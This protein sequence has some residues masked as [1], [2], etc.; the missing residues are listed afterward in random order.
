LIPVKSFHD[1]KERLAGVLSRAERQQLA[2]S[3]AEGVISALAS[4]VVC[5]V[6]DDDEVASWARHVGAGVVWAPG[7]GL[8]PAVATG[9]D[10]LKAQ[11]F[12][13]VTIVHA[14]LP[15]P[16]RLTALPSTEGALLVPDR[17]GDGTNVLR[18]PTGVS[19]TFAYGPGSFARHEHEARRLGL[20]VIV[21]DD[22]EL[23]LD[24]DVPDDLVLA[25][26]RTRLWGPE[27]PHRSTPR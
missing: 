14:D 9:V 2:R 3:L 10:H 8:N 19:F 4:R 13:T 17:H 25:E 16:E 24:I 23:A 27:G 7:K 11:G 22:A 5:V 15:S 18:I 6:C 1:A 12:E 21:V 20:E 26:A